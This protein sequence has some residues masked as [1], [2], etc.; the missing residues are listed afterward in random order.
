LDTGDRQFEFGRSPEINLPTETC[1]EDGRHEHAMKLEMANFQA[2]AASLTIEGEVCD[3]PHAKLWMQAEADAE[4]APVIQKL[5]AALPGLVGAGHA[6]RFER[7]RVLLDFCRVGEA[8]VGGGR[9]QTAR[10]G[11]SGDWHFLPL[12]PYLRRSMRTPS[13]R[14]AAKLRSWRVALM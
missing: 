7:D 1:D 14:K 4:M 12:L 9:R 6:S 3:L 2:V 8:S 10:W 5:G 13:K 11:E